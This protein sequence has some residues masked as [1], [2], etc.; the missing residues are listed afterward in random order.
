M[1]FIGSIDYS[2]GYTTLTQRNPAINTQ[3]LIIWLEASN[4]TSGATWSNL[5]TGQPTYTLVNSPTT[6]NVTYNGQATIGMSF[7]G[8]T[9]YT[10]PSASLLAA[11]ASNN[12]AETKELWYYN[13]SG[14]GT[15]FNEQ[16]TASLDLNWY[17]YQA[18]LSNTSLIYSIWSGNNPQTA[19]TANTGMQ[20]NTWYHIVWQH[21]RTNNQFL[22]YV[23]GTLT[24]SNIVS[25][26][27]PTTGYYI[28]IAAPTATTPVIGSTYFNGLIGAF[29]WYNTTLTAAQ[30]LS[31]FNAQR[32]Q[33]GV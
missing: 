1:P 30:I 2:L 18:G 4:Y 23:N 8:S 15:F 28:F 12:W 14:N 19:Y 7:N 29:R 21:N 13:R 17:D 20:P 22:A 11:A 31:N 24:M 33:Y 3:N 16:G 26:E 25:R 6:S 32:G 27:I 5:V 9:Q 10:R